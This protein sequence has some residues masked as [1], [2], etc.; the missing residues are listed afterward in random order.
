MRKL[1]IIVKLSM[2]FGNSHTDA[3]ICSV[4][5]IATQMSFGYLVK[6]LLE[7]SGDQYEKCKKCEFWF[8]SSPA[9]FLLRYLAHNSPI[10][11]APQ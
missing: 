2:N 11:E 10:R 4:I 1:I 5:L 9:D 6:R 7:L 8:L 3:Y